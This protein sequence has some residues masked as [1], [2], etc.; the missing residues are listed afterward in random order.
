MSKTD[1]PWIDGGVIDGLLDDLVERIERARTH[2]L[3]RVSKNV[4]DPFL[5]LCVAST[6]GITDVQQLK[7][8]GAFHSVSSAISS[9]IG[10]F[11]QGVLGSVGGFV[12]HDAGYDVENR[13]RKILAEIKNKHNTMNASNR[14]SVVEDLQTTLRSR[15]GYC[16]YLVTIIPKR[17][18]RYEID[19]GGR[20]FETDG[21]SFY[22]LATGEENALE[23]LYDMLEKR[24]CADMPKI[25]VYC[26]QAFN[27]GIPGAVKATE[28]SKK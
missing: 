2:A 3:T 17:K 8:L 20:L 26:R 9:A 24:L 10:E 5:L 23:Q 16:G 4:E 28:T 1:L 11:H 18:K 12:N 14:K 25:A 15:P 21:A 6:Y 19:L 27:R 7:E 13:E 22:A